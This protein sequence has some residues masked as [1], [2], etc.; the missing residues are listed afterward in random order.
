MDKHIHVM[1]CG[2][3]LEIEVSY[4]WI[5]QSTE[6]EHV[7]ILKICKQHREFDYE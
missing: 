7:V 1:L 6:V 2:C 4:N 5:D 3:E